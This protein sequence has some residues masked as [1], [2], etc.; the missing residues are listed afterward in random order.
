MQDHD[1]SQAEGLPCGCAGNP[2]PAVTRRRFV[3]VAAGAIASTPLQ[4]M[5]QS[6]PET[7]QPVASPAGESQIDLGTL[8]TVSQALVG[9]GTL[10]DA[11]LETLGGLISADPDRVAAFGELADLDDPSAPDALDAMSPGARS[12]VDDIVQFWYLG[13]F[14]GK[15]VENR[16]ELYFKLPVWTTVPYAAQPTLCKAFGYWAMDV[17]LD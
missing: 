6:T 16:A 15:P 9:G 2:G 3:S 4:V 11:A 7:G 17:S 5:A 12:L 10:N 14:D 1:L 13:N 8:M